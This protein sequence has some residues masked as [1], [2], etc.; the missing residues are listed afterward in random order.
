MNIEE[1]SRHQSRNTPTHAVTCLHGDF[2]DAL[3]HHPHHHHH[4]HTTHQSIQC[5]EVTPCIPPSRDT[6][7]HTHTHVY[8]PLTPTQARTHPTCTQPHSHTDMTAMAGWAASCRRV[9]NARPGNSSFLW[10]A[11]GRSTGH[12]PQ[13][14]LPYAACPAKKCFSCMAAHAQGRFGVKLGPVLQTILQ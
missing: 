2:P 6:H 13:H 9:A 1:W 4:A 5:R 8:H 12:W 7:V 10:A 11:R 14:Q 3:T